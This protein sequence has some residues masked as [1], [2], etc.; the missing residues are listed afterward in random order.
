MAGSSKH[1][2]PRSGAKLVVAIVVV[3]AIVAVTPV[4]RAD[5]PPTPGFRRAPVDLYGPAP[6]YECLRADPR[7]PG[8]EGFIAIVLAAYP[9][10]VSGD[11]W[12][13]C[14]SHSS[15]SLH[16]SGRAWDWVVAAD[17]EIATPEV[18]AQ[19]DE[20]LRWLLAPEGTEPHARARR[21][22]IVEIIWFD[23]LW[24]SGTRAWVPYPVFDCTDPAV[25][26]TTCHRDH[27]HFTF[28]RSG[29]DAQTTWWLGWRGFT[30]SALD[31]VRGLFAAMLSL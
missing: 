5:P 29:A 15:T 27:A 24:T 31:S 11:A 7:R 6:T 28:S 30:W 13:P 26:N 16:H 21:L 3:M 1:P 25:S 9:N 17:N 18:R 10:T 4:A 12:A 19:V 22:G 2:G 20:L 8:T 23:Q 14:D